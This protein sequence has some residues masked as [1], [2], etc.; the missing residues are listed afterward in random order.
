M[1]VAFVIH[2]RL[3]TPALSD[4]ILEGITRESILI[5][6]KEWGIPVE[7]RRISVDEIVAAAKDGS[8]EEAF[9]MGTAAVVSPIDGL[10]YH[11]AIIPVP[12]PENGVAM[13][14]KSALADIRYGRAA[15]RHQWMTQI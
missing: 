10:G 13:R 1:N 11:E 7:E 4:R 8:L 9:G 5:L 14:V 6:A 2:G 3:I 15:D 12:A